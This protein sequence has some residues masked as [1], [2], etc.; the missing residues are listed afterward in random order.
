MAEA[1][2]GECLR[3]A[4]KAGV[5]VCSAGLAAYPGSP[6]SPGAH[7]V[8]KECSIDLSGFRSTRVSLP[9]LESAELIVTM[10]RS[11]RQSI[12]GACPEM[13]GKVRTLL[14]N[15]DVPDPYGGDTDEYRK[16]FE[17]MRPALE[18]LC[19]EL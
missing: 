8:M 5:E 2:A 12:C 10:S 4:G 15:A 11:H 17:A 19:D 7:E 9:L 3:L 13:S 14:D 18:K 16:V 1:Y 6:A